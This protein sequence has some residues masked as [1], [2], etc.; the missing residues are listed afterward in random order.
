MLHPGAHVRRART[1]QRHRLALHVRSHQR[2]VRVVVL[3][4]RDQRGGHRDQLLR[5]YVDEVDVLARGEHEVACLPAI[6]PRVDEVAP[7]VDLRVRL[8]DDVAVFL[9]GGQV[10]RVRHELRRPLLARLGVGVRFGDGVRVDDLPQ[11]ELRAAAVG[12]AHIVDGP[13][14]LDPAV[15]RLDEA[16]FV[17]PRVA[18]QR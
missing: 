7:V 6:D 13:S 1:Q 16:E 12:D 15:G 18:G 10:E 17:D 9:P 4:E 11:L 5:R 3:E 14:G 2:P 8:R